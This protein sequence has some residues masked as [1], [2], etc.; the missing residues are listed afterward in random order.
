MKKVIS[1]ILAAVIS[2]T[3]V[4]VSAAGEENQNSIVYEKKNVNAVIDENN[5]ID[6]TW[7]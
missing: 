1:V 6:V 4:S 2:L 5:S 3:C 7:R